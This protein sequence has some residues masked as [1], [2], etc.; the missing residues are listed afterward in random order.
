MKKLMNNVKKEKGFTLL[1]VIVTL[2]VAAIMASFLVTFMG[3]AI[4]KSS[5][6]IKQTRDLGSS[7]QSI[8]IVSAAYNCYLT[9]CTTN[10]S[11]CSPT[12]C[13]CTWTR[14]KTLCGT[15]GTVSTVASGSDIYNANYET[16]QFTKITNNQKQISYFME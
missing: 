11:C 1:E 6:P 5:D 2:T 14:F 15:N 9:K 13:E 10:S 12:P 7:I 8:E 16:I 3:T 4:S